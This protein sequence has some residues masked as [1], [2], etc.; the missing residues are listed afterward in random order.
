MENALARRSQEIRLR[1][2]S[3]ITF[4]E[5]MRQFSFLESNQLFYKSGEDLKQNQSSA[6]SKQY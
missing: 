1:I 3:P 2:Q 5:I 4:K 6:L